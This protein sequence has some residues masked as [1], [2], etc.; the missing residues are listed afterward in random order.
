MSV[1]VECDVRIYSYTSGDLPGIVYP[2][3]M[4]NLVPAV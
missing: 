4:L 1:V 2:R 3:Y